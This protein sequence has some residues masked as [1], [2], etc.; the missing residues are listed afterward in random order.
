MAASITSTLQM[1]AE[2]TEARGTTAPATPPISMRAALAEAMG[3]RAAFSWLST[4]LVCQHWSA[5]FAARG[6]NAV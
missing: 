6:D 1:L 3:T 4:R 5:Y 2:M